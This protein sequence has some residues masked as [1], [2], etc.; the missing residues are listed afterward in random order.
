MGRL[1][2]RLILFPCLLV[3]LAFSPLWAEESKE[4]SV[5]LRKQRPP[6]E[7]EESIL[8]LTFG[9]PPPLATERGIL[10]IDAFFDRNGNGRHDPGE[11]VLKDVITCT[12]DGID[13]KVPAFIPGLDYQETFELSCRGDDYLPILAD[14]QVFVGKRGQILHLNLPCRRP[15]A[16]K[17]PANGR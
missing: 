2:G 6:R 8:D 15:D 3:A 5:K 17:R 4:T 14:S 9:A 10:I 11:D 13:Y 12:L 7:P 1:L 16:V